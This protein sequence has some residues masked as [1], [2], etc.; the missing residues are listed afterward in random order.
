MKNSSMLLL[1]LFLAVMAKLAVA[2][3]PAAADFVIV[4]GGTAG[5]VLAARLC[6]SLP[7]AKIV[8]LE[9]APPRDAAADFIV[10]APRNAWKAFV[11]P[12]V[13]E[14]FPSEPNSG[15]N[16]RTLDLVT[17]NTLGGSSAVNGIQWVV[18]TKGTVESWGIRGLT[19]RSSGKYYNRA[20]K[21]V[22]FAIP[23]PSLKHIY[24]RD[25]IQAAAS[26]GIS[27]SDRPSNGR[28]DYAIWENRVAVNKGRRVDSCTAYLSPA[29]KGQCVDNLT[30]MEGATVTKL[31]F[32]NRRNAQ[33]ITGVEYV[34]TSDVRLRNKKILVARK[35]VILSAGPYGSP[36]VLQ[37]SGIGPKHLLSKIGID[38]KADLPVGSKTQLRPLNIVSALYLTKPIEPSNN[39]TI[40]ASAATRATWESGRGGPLAK[41]I[42]AI[43]GRFKRESYF[44]T[45]FVFPEGG[46]LGSPLIG[47]GCLP[48]P[49]SFG[50]LQITSKNPFAPLKVQANILGKK[51]DFH[52]MISCMRRINGVHQSFPLDFGIRNATPLASDLN[53][54][55]VR[56]STISGYHFVGGC[57]VGSV[58]KPDLRVKRVQGLRVV[59][60]SVFRELPSSAGPMAS[61]YM[62]AEFAASKIVSENK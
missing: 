11:S 16:G 38:M 43:N 53:E 10:R 35:E 33:R 8:L 5:C 31:V 54:S 22:G 28:I 15:L 41:A 42:G 14:I 32:G 2:N 23:E 51:L 29:L 55:Y 49:A 20:F 34:D 3:D 24:V 59:D 39:A 17:G 62:L 30:L 9:R 7:K 37:Q 21:K 44:G 50:F 13:V 48:N 27:E 26:R 40:L 36:K 47:T 52:R 18:P 58:L 12:S 25:Y 56:E 60:A 1:H 6:E 46:G 57:A 45:A 61:V 4:G 19:T